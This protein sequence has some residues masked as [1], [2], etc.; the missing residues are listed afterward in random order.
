MVINWIIQATNLI[1]SIAIV[2]FMI[3]LI[4][5]ALMFLLGSGSLLL[6]GTGAAGAV[7]CGLLIYQQIPKIR[8]ILII[9]IIVNLII[10]FFWK[11]Y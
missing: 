5:R 11:D 4:F 2:D 7:I 3:L 1:I 6:M 8:T 9:L 10:G